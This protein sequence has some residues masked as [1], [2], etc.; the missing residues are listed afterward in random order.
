MLKKILVNILLISLTI[1]TIII[2]IYATI[3]GMALSHTTP[4]SV[5]FILWT[6][7]FVCIAGLICILRVQ[8][9]KKI[10]TNVLLASL[11]LMAIGLSIPFYFL[12]MLGLA[13]KSGRQCIDF[14]SACLLWTFP[15]LCIVGL[16][17]ILRIQKPVKWWLW[18]L[19][20]PLMLLSGVEIVFTLWFFLEK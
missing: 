16:I 7:F 10:W 15:I 11:S 5:I 13:M 3:L 6:T 18:F 14:S 12:T 1:T 20:V 17:C 9:S 19:T 4:I 2:S 8:K